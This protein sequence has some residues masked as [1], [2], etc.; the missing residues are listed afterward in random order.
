[1]ALIGCLPLLL[2]VLSLLTS[3]WRWLW[4][5]VPL[6]AV[7]YLPYLVL[8]T[9]RR[10]RSASRHVSDAEQARPHFVIALVPTRQEELS[11]GYLRV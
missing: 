9:G 8:K 4:Y 10:Y 11:G 6:L 7:A 1:L 5:L 2:I 3:R